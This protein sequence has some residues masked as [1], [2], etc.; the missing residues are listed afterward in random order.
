MR[1]TVKHRIT[2]SIILG[3]VLFLFV[4][5]GAAPTIDQAALEATITARI[6]VTQTASAPTATNTPANT[7][8]PTFTPTPTNTPTP[9]VT[10]TPTPTGTPT[11]TAAPDILSLVPAKR[12][13]NHPFKIITE[14]DKFKDRTFITLNYIPSSTT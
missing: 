6:I 10:N 11:P 14:Y 4:G 1:T 5:C 12:K 8:T 13:F 2:G 9:A 7:A 3:M